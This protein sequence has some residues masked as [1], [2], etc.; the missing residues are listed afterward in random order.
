MSNGVAFLFSFSARLQQ[1]G[2]KRLSYILTGRRAV[3]SI[4]S[5]L[6]EECFGVALN[7]LIEHLHSIFSQAEQRYDLLFLV[8]G[9]GANEYTESVIRQE[10]E[11]FC[12]V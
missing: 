8:G 2:D 1:H 7:P 6:V 9:M 11:G 12:K 5:S 10:F 4:K 3:I